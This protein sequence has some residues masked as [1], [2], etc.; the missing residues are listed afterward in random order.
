MTTFEPL[1]EGRSADSAV[2]DHWDC[3]S[4]HSLLFIIVRLLRPS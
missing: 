2:Y 3:K 1:F 4:S